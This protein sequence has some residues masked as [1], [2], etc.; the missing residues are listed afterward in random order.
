M[1]L[2]ES[3]ADELIHTAYARE[4]GDAAILYEG[5]SLAD[6]AHVVGLIE[7]NIIPREAGGE[8]LA[9]LLAIHPT[10]PLDFTFDPA[11]GDLY[12]NREAYLKMLTPAV[13]WLSAGGA[14]TGAAAACVR[15]SP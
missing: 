7:S 15:T 1:R 14:H 13:A 8:L 2:K 3:P 10:P 6:I 5:M 12:S 11:R 4:V 9:A